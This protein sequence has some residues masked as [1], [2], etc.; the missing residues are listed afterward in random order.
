MEAG[1]RIL[2]EKMEGLP[3][4]RSDNRSKTAG[5]G[6]G[7]RPTVSGGETETMTKALQE[8]DQ[9]ETDFCHA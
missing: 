7:R 2:G 8:R 1:P 9:I 6:G 3:H 4:S 5:Y